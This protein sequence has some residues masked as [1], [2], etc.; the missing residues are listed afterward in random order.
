LNRGLRLRARALSSTRVENDGRVTIRDTGLTLDCFTELVEAVLL[1]YAAVEAMVN[2]MIE[3][4]DDCVTIR[5]V[6]AKGVEVELDKA[7]MVRRMSTAEK[8]NVAIPLVTG[9]PSVKGTVFWDRFVRLRRIRDALVHIKQGG[10][11]NDADHPSEFGMLLRGDADDCVLD[12]IALVL[13]LNPECLSEATQKA[14]KI[15]SIVPRVN[16]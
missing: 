6:N 16:A 4:L 13:K 10:Y 7:E 5:R 3:S 2:E 12:A 15:P 14:L 8:L 11:S 9:E 1:S